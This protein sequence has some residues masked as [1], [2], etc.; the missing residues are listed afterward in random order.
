[1][2]TNV[3]FYIYI[4]IYILNLKMCAMKT[5]GT[6]FNCKQ[7]RWEKECEK[8]L[9]YENASVKIYTQVK[10]SDFIDVNY[11]SHTLSEIKYV[12][13]IYECSYAVLL[14]LHV[15]IIL[16]KTIICIVKVKYT[17][18]NMWESVKQ[19]IYGMSGYFIMTSQVHFVNNVSQ[20]SVKK[21]QGLLTYFIKGF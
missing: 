18:N 19:G 21:C 7:N 16:F 13:I 20:W 17:N 9:I 8:M 11:C 12:C 10:R 1:M 4:Y 3:R 14:I 5:M 6:K 2:T 15:K